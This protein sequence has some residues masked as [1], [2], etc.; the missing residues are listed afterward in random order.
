MIK[1]RLRRTA[2]RQCD[3]ATG[4]AHFKC[5]SV[6]HTGC[7][8]DVQAAVASLVNPM[9]NSTLSCFGMHTVLTYFKDTVP[10]DV[11]Y[12]TSDRGCYVEQSL[13]SVSYVDS[14][15]CWLLVGY[16]F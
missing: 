13:P 1:G 3:C 16:L 2:F 4:Y 9:R 12:F 15:I 6:L 7:L 14:S 10:T 8:K 5:V 11:L